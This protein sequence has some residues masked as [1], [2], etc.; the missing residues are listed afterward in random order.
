MSA[1]HIVLLHGPL[2]FAGATRRLL[3]S[4]TL[5][6]Q[7]GHRVTV[8][9]SAGT[10]APAF[11]EVGITVVEMEVGAHNPHNP[12]VARRLARRLR[13][14]EPDLLHVTGSGLAATGA[15][16]AARLSLPYVL[17]IGRPVTGRIP[18]DTSL[19]AAV[20]LTC[21]TLTEGVVNRGRLPRD[22]LRV[23]EHGPTVPADTPRTLFQREPVVI[24]TSGYLDHDLGTDLFIEAARLLSLSGRRLRF[25]IL[26]EGP[27]E[28]H[29]RRQARA[30]AIE[31]LVTITAPASPETLRLLAQLDLHVNCSRECG[32]GWLAHEALA[33]GLPSVMTAVSSAF[34]LI[35]D[36]V[37]GL[38]VEREDPPRLAAAITR[39]LDD[40]AA[41]QAMGREASQRLMAAGPE[42]APTG[43]YAAA[44]TAL[45]RGLLPQ[46]A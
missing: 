14:L 38:L 22:L 21:A 31:H 32:P 18:R 29:L 36:G 42:E 11:A 37:S 5:L 45:Y 27:R 39:L 2:A 8:M 10:R 15:D 40:P 30:A 6:R 3:V 4:A 20:V 28:Q 26:G 1:S 19:L 13:E 46:P 41:A 9:A 33:L 43:A 23:L 44:L 25:L 17:E 12:F 24:G 16:L 35:E 34:A 7:E